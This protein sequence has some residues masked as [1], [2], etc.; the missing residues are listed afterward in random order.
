MS[1]DE[2]AGFDQL[3]EHLRQA[4]GF[5]FTGYK[6]PSLQRRIARRM[7][8][9]D[10]STYPEYQD[11]LEVHP[12]EFSEL[13]NAV[14]INVTGFFR[15]EAVWEC[16]RS[17][18]VPELLSAKGED[19]PIRVWSAGCA[20]G[21]EPY[22]L[23]MLLAQAMGAEQFKERVKIYATDVD[24]EALVTARAASYTERDLADMP[25]EF[26]DGLFEQE[27]GR[28]IFSKDLRRSVIFG[29]HD[30]IQDAPIS[31]IDLLVCR[32]TMIYL[33]SETQSRI[34]SRFNFALNDDGFLL[35]G[36]A[37]MLLTHSNLFVPFDLR[38]RIF[39]KAAV[40]TGRTRG[41]TRASQGPAIAPDEQLR[42][43]VLETSPVVQIVLD[44]D[45][46]LTLSN[47]RAAAMFDLAPSDVGRLLAELDISYRP[48]ELRRHLDQ[49]AAE[50]RPLRL[51]EIE[52]PRTPTM[53]S[54]V[55][56]EIVP[57]LSIDGTLLGMSISFIDVTRSHQLQTELEQANAELETAFEELQSTNEEL[58][59]TNEELQSTVEELETTNEELQSTNEELET[60]NE[61]LH[62]TNN[63][64]QSINGL[65]R[66]RT[67]DLNSVNT[68]L[69]SILSSMD[70]GV[71]VVDEE[72]R[73]R[74][75]NK[76]A[77]ELWGLRAD[78][79][80]GKHLLTLDIGLPVESLAQPMRRAIAE[81]KAAD[82]E[83]AAVNR[84]GR[85]VLCLVRVM[86]LSQAGS[87]A[88]E[89]ADGAVI[90]M[91]VAV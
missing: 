57:L 83:I 50:R 75:W 3:L 69:Q 82:I 74:I 88:D 19:A 38:R 1:D 52:W 79:V 46:R 24:D 47:E 44:T 70:N 81:R 65:L 11:F 53:R 68:Y 28:F 17:T 58:E 36:K 49:V 13:F 26:R 7:T 16:M 55:D 87:M 90:I 32:N 85:D 8:S 67:N 5:D 64:L 35:L 30:L 22:S 31:R 41:T 15:D 12:D 23:A 63:E 39:R 27:Q 34:L 18:L 73:V 2:S 48:V 45:G 40:T 21:E 84:R 29:R 86:P 91:S 62:S 14:L 9:L 59:T 25:A 89:T 78:E 33:N 56:I 42:Q 37:E 4:R 10:V 60:M 77:E 66:E 61:E 71:V 43:L 6:R 76:V 20:S 51:R 80:A 72:M 54:Y